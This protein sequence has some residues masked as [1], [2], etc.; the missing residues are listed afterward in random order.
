MA[1]PKLY[2]FL[3]VIGVLLLVL[4]MLAFVMAATFSMPGNSNNPWLLLGG[5]GGFVMGI[6]LFNIVGAWI[7]QYLGHWVTIICI[8]LGAA[9]MTAS[10]LLLR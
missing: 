2:Q 5:A 6:G 4:P 1:H 9:M 10:W 8:G 3:A 7:E